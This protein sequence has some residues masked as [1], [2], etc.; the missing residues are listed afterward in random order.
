MSKKSKPT[1]PETDGAI[2]VRA[3]IDNVKPEHRSIVARTD[4]LIDELIPDVHRGIKW[5]KASQPLGI[6]FYGTAEQGW[7]VAMWSFKDKVGIGF[8]AGTELDPEPP[9]TKMAGPWNRGPMKGRRID[10]HSEDQFDEQPSIAIAASSAAIVAVSISSVTE[11][12]SWSAFPAE[13]GMIYS[14][15][16]RSLILS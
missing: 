8:I 14:C 9:I 5:R 16:R 4:A 10:L 12:I 3:W 2:G 15:R 11:L 1:Q 7:I 13:M 6:P